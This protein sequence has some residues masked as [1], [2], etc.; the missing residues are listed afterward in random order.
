MSKQ[1]RTVIRPRDSRK[2]YVREFWD[3]R[4]LLL[5]LT[6]REFKVRY[7]QTAIGVLWVLLRPLFTVLILSFVFGR[8]AGLDTHTVPYPLMVLAGM[9]PWQ[10]FSSGFTSGTNSVVADGSIITKVYFP[11]IIIPIS[12]VCANLLDFLITLVLVFGLLLWYG[13]SFSFRVLWLLPFLLLMLFFTLGTSFF[14]AAW[15][16]KYRDFRYL[17]PFI[18]QFGL[19]LSPVG[20]ALE[21]VPESYQTWFALNPLVGII[22]GFRWCLI[23]SWTFP[24]QEL[25]VSTIGTLALFLLG[26]TVFHRVERQFVDI[27]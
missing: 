13:Q 27:I 4:E 8:V 7:K 3:Y 26:L 23:P 22:E 20:F 24:A 5:I 16:V 9:V 19:Y 2:D 14:C 11:R 21:K 15:N 18:L 10:F 17:V 25:M 1:Q 6:W 12:A